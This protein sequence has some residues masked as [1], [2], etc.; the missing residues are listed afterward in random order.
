MGTFR[1]G[2]MAKQTKLDRG[3]ATSKCRFDFG[4]IWCDFS[5]NHLSTERIREA[6][7]DF[8]ALFSGITL[9][10]ASFLD[11]GVGQGFGSLFA[12]EIGAKVVGVDSSPKCLKAVEIT[13]KAFPKNCGRNLIDNRL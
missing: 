8:R 3:K 5:E 6:R 13:R 1:F 2:A 4:Q 10:S 7:R 12:E 11:V 9:Q